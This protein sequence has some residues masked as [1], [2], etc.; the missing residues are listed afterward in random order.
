[1]SNHLLGLGACAWALIA[2]LGCS[3]QPDGAR[4]VELP[5]FAASSLTEAFAALERG[6]EAAHPEVDV[7]LSFAGSQVLRVQIE[8]GATAAVFASANPAHMQALLTG[9]HAAER[10]VF[11]RNGLVV[12]VP[13]GNP[14]G[15]MHFEQLDRAR[16]LVVGAETA[17][18]GRYT[19]QLLDRAR[20]KLGLPFATAVQASVV[21]ME[22]N[23]RLVRAKVELGEADAAVVYRTD[24][25][26]TVRAVPIPPALDVEASYQIA[27]LRRARQPEWAARFVDFVLSDEGQALLVGAGF[28]PSVR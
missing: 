19:R 22:S 3:T 1:M 12:I 25:S 7:Q 28:R 15:I 17:P 4:R 10:H 27:P 6:F 9:D 8:Q 23:A 13:P 20:S 11:A 2:L 24:V 5:V 14:A 21:S 26:P 16:R 18:I